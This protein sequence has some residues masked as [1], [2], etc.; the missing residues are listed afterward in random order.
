MGDERSC[1]AGDLSTD[2]LTKTIDV[3]VPG[4]PPAPGHVLTGVLLKVEHSVS[5][6]NRK[7]VTF[8]LI[9]EGSGAVGYSIQENW[10][11]VVR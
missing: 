2:Q 3:H 8:I 10:K 5:F 4:V 7:P 9:D 11:V 1:Y 6:L